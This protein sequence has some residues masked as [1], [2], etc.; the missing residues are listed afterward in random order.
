MLD[1]LR[2]N[3]PARRAYYRLKMLRGVHGQSDETRILANLTKHA[4]KA[5]V[6]F[7]FH[8]VQFNCA[9]LARD[10]GWRGLLIDGSQ[11]QVDDA[12]A[13]F[14]ERIEIEQRFLTLDNLDFIAAKFPG[15]G[16]LSIDVDGNDFW[17]LERLIG[18]Q[19]TVISVEYN[20]SFGANS[21]TVPYDPTFDRH[22][23][24]PSGWYHGASLTALAKLCAKSGYGLAAVSSA[25]GNA[26]FTKTGALDPAVSWRPSKLRDTWSGTTPAS[27][28]E[29]IKH[30]PFVAI[31]SE[32]V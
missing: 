9:A 30:L 22:A 21:V 32:P 4:P 6:E 12:R 2:S 23:K 7:G 17:F 1:F 25:G 27:Q 20:A 29:A 11:R 28:W 10:A 8:P 16:V 26:F 24:H 31:E 3:A 15:L 19:P 18:I 14:P 13:I 5:F